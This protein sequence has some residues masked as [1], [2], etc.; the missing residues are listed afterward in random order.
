L[1]FSFSQ[2]RQKVFKILFPRYRPDV[3]MDAGQLRLLP[4]IQGR[5]KRRSFRHSFRRQLLLKRHL[6]QEILFNEPRMEVVQFFTKSNF[7]HYLQRL[8]FVCI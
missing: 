7:V 5:P 2:Y 3:A 6:G 8:L 1:Y 4:N